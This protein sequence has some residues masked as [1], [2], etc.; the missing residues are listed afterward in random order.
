MARRRPNQSVGWAALGL[1]LV[2]AAALAAGLLVLLGLGLIG[3]VPPA[4]SWAQDRWASL[5]RS[6]Q[7]PQW[8]RHTAST[9]GQHP[10]ATGATAVVVLLVL[11]VAS[12]TTNTAGGSSGP[13]VAAP[14][15]SSD[16]STTPSAAPVPTGSAPD[17]VGQK[18]D[19]AG[20]Q[21]SGFQVLAVDLNTT[22]SES[23]AIGFGEGWTVVRQSAVTGQRNVT[24]SALQTS[25]A[26]W[27]TQHR[28][29]PNVVGQD[30]TALTASPGVLSDVQELVRSDP[31][32]DPV[33]TVIKQSPAAGT[34]VDLSR[35][36]V[37][38]L[39]EPATPTPDSS[40]GYEEPSL[41]N[42]PNPNLPGHRP[43]VH[44]GHGHLHF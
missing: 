43:R 24:L 33:G 29:M 20:Q 16:T 4:R 6:R 19:A 37:V 18:L 28:Q 13:A 44:V 8:V 34:P 5:A 26:R 31:Q 14:G 12:T 36:I 17:V 22:R 15:D 10:N 40:S 25:E 1:A 23:I 2:I 11:V 3:L 21:L 7:L 27:R 42:I 30:Y 41:P 38:T 35:S 39:K 32:G 9:A